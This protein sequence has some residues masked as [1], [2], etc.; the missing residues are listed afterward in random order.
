MR[1]YHMAQAPKYIACPLGLDVIET[2]SG[3]RQINQE[4]VRLARH[5]YGESGIATT[6][7][8][9]K[10]APQRRTRLLCYRRCPSAR[11]GSQALR[12]EHSTLLTSENLS[13]TDARLWEIR[14]EPPPGPEAIRSAR[15]RIRSPS[16]SR[17]TTGTGLRQVAPPGLPNGRRAG[18]QGVPFWRSRKAS[19]D[20]GIDRSEARPLR[21]DRQHRPR[22]RGKLRR[23]VGLDDNQSALSQGRVTH[24]P[25]SRSRRSRR[26]S[27]RRRRKRRRKPSKNEREAAEIIL[28]HV[29]SNEIELLLRLMAN[30]R[31]GP[32]RSAVRQAV[33]RRRKAASEAAEQPP[34]VEPA[35]EPSPEPE[36]DATAPEPVEQPETIAAKANVVADIALAE[37]EGAP[38]EFLPA[39]QAIIDAIAPEPVS[40]HEKKM[41]AAASEV[42]GEELA[43]GGT[44]S[45]R[46][47]LVDAFFAKGGKVTHCPVSKRRKA[48]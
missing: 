26:S 4:A 27:R 1:F 15:G 33:E 46:D 3:R 9:C 2:R 22:R 43:G 37:I 17:L 32:L 34:A 18:P 13:A 42:V 12:M 11:S 31:P 39:D 5:V 40:D 30:S 29:P 19:R 38:R 47:S 28:R 36:V 7:Y 25:R 20:L 41:A 8:R 14:R 45:Q 48:A 23:A 44:M 6:N 35:A 24:H 10:K 16:G 21:Q